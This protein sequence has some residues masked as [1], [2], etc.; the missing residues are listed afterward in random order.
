MNRTDRRSF[1]KIAGSSLGIGVLYSVYPAAHSRG[2]AGDLL[3]NP[4]DGGREAADHG[5]RALRGESSDRNGGEYPRRSTKLRVLLH[6][7]PRTGRAEHRRALADKMAP[8]V[9]P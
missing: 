1:L 7:V 2:E 3:A 5:R 9:P 4:A 8:P 6:G